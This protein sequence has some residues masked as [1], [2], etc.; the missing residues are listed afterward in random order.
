VIDA[1]GQQFAQAM[2]LHGECGITAIQQDGKLPHGLFFAI[3]SV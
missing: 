1:S 3:A 2:Q